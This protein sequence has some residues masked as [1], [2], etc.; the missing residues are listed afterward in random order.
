MGMQ[1]KVIRDQLL[2]ALLDYIPGFDAAQLEELLEKLLMPDDEVSSPA[3][4][5]LLHQWFS[6]Y[7]LVCIEF[8]C[9][10]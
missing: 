10:Y 2:A 8:Q 4:I 9:L 1:V 5:T 6:R 7:V 3:Y